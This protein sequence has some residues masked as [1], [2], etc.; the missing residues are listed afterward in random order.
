ML[1]ELLLG[2]T[3]SLRVTDVV[4]VHFSPS[5]TSRPVGCRPT[6]RQVDCRD[7]FTRVR[8]RPSLTRPAARRYKSCKQLTMVMGRNLSM[9]EFVLSRVQCV[10]ARR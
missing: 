9:R 7:A 3:R 5:R 2:G 1:F 8:D 6:V 10:Q 4:G